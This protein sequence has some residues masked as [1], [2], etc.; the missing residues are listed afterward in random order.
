[1]KS[2]HI[3][4]PP[5][6][7]IDSN[8]NLHIET[9][10]I[11][12]IDSDKNYKIFFKLENTQP[13]GSFKLRGIG[14]HCQKLV[15]RGCCHFVSSSGGNAGLAVAYVGFKL[16]VPVTVFV[17]ETTAIQVIHTL[18]KEHAKVYVKG[19]VWDEAHFYAQKFVEE[20]EGSTLVHPFDHPE[21][22]SGHSTMIHEIKL[23]LPEPPSAILLSVGGGGLLCGVLEGLHAVGWS[24]VPV[25]AFETIGADCFNKAIEA[26]Y[27]IKL[28]E[29]KSIAKCLGSLSVLPNAL[30]WY[31]KH[32]IFSHVVTDKTAVLAC[33]QFANDHKML[34]EPACGASLSAI[35]NDTLEIL[36]K[37]GSIPDLSSIVVIVCGGQAVNLDDIQLWK[38]MFEL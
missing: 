23:K 4:T 9:P 35:Y 36:H 28:P 33:L 29:I 6:D 22:W 11:E 18:E 14:Y 10:L 21:I 38:E 37:M 26:G 27:P 13:S 31:G 12:K 24:G 15:E 25:I 20:H 1:M 5:I 3:E 34:V 32:K 16:E 30:E 19:S 7:K 2:L 8:K 17:P